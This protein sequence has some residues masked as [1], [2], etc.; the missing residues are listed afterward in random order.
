LQVV[1]RA[2]TLKTMLT[3]VCG[4]VAVA[5]Q[6]PTL[7]TDTSMSFVFENGNAGQ[8]SS[9][10]GTFRLRSG[11]GWLRVPKVFS[12]FRLTLEFRTV[13]EKTDAGVAVRTWTGRGG[14][15]DEGYRIRLLD[16][17]SNGAASLF[18]GRR[19]K[20]TPA[21]P[22]AAPA[23]RGVGEWQRL[24][25]VGEAQRV[26]VNV[27]GQPAGVFEIEERAGNVLLDTRKGTTEFRNI[28]IHAIP[29]NDDRPP[30]AMSS[31]SLTAGG[32]TLP[33]VL[34]EVRPRYSYEAIT[35]NLEGK[36]TLE[37]VVLPSGAP[38]GIRVTGSL[39][40][41]LDEAAIAA[42]QRWRFKPATLN[43]QAVPVVV[44]VEL[45]FTMR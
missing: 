38:A 17:R 12:N 30:T 29:R 44:L 45:T 39:D 10:N 8:F 40:P 33:I 18:E 15:P 5:A 2:V 19:R 16:S 3:L 43:G 21:P 4:A 11:P 26:T 32:G 13:E 27:N 41:D 36:V 22:A 37:A 35:R 34:T 31:D 6:A 24:E 20:V 1:L 42:L 25:V 28:A 14:W 7:W 9:D 23:W